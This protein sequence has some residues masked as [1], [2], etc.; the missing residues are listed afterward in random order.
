M[1][2][3][4]FELQ[5]KVATIKIQNGKVNAISHQVIAELNEALDH[6]EETGA[7]V[8]ITGQ[9]GIFSGGYDLKTMQ[10]SMDHAT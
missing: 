3:V 1:E 7:V 9:E 8:I 6:A 10:K 4:Q 5:D 2:L